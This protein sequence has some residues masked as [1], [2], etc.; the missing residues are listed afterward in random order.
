MWTD[1][2]Y[3]LQA[4][5]QLEAGWTMMKLEKDV[6]SWFEFTKTKLT[7]NQVVGID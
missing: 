4:E 2:R 5:R 1:G 7:A 3:Y 6:P